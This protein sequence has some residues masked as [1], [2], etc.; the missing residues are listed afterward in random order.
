MRIQLLCLL[1]VGCLDGRALPTRD[2]ATV[3]A[4][5]DAKG[6]CC[7]DGLTWLGCCGTPQHGPSHTCGAPSMLCQAPC[8]DQHSC[9]GPDGGE[10]GQPCRTDCDCDFKHSFGCEAGQ[11]VGV[12]RVVECECASDADCTFVDTGCCSAECVGFG[13]TPQGPFCDLDCGVSGSCLCVAGHCGLAQGSSCR[14]TPDC[15]PDLLCCPSSGI[16]ALS[17]CTPPGPGGSCAPL[18]P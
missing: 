12:R 18:P 1:A 5:A 8:I 2:G 9:A 17:A 3:D 13:G 7:E 15:S 4:S 10:I 6:S 14:A 16:R 11:C